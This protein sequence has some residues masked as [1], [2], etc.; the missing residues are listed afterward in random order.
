MDMFI[1]IRDG[2]PYQHPIVG[3]NFREAFPRIDTNALPPE[4]A[5]FVRKPPAQLPGPDEVLV[6]SYIW[7]GD[8]VTDSWSIRPMTP[9]EK[10]AMAARVSR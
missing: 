9:E 4:F 8:V 3:E 7:D 10:A 5:R 6:E 1:Q 2:Q